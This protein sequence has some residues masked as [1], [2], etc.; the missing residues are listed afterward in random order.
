MA[1]ISKEERARREAEKQTI[2]KPATVKMQRDKSI[3]PPPHEC[4]VHP[5]ELENY[6]GGGWTVKD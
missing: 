6:R 1:N 5:D 3:Y 4:D 2:A